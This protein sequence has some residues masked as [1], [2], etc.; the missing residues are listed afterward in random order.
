MGDGA[1][2]E[3]VD[4]RA[5]T[6]LAAKLDQLFQE[7]ARANGKPPSHAEVAR[8]INARS[9]GRT[10]SGVYIWQLRTG[11]KDN[12]TKRHLEALADYFRVPPGYFFD[13]AGAPPSP[14]AAP[15][16]GAHHR[17]SA[18]SPAPFRV[19]GAAEWTAGAPTA[20]P[21]GQALLDPGTVATR[22]RFLFDHVHPQSGP[23]TDED[24]AEAVNGNPAKYGGVRL[25]PATVAALREGRLPDPAPDGDAPD[26]PTDSA[27][28]A[29]LAA[30]ASFFGVG[31]DYLLGDD[32]DAVARTE[33]EVRFLATLRDQRVR[34]VALRAAGLPPEILDTLGTMIGQFRA[35]LNLPETATAATPATAAATVGG[36]EP[37]QP[38]G[39]GTGESHGNAIR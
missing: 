22:L 25:A 26:A 2:D 18:A 21:A 27:L 9:G 10:I 11:K 4:E 19:P 33:E 8:A 16:A 5:G 14:V 3:Q 31:A 30:V 29:T 34:Q 15:S 35:Q 13:D 7:A 24:V 39:A 32:P 37:G 28:P 20:G 23:Y 1:H 6:D 17:P 38:H 36:A 12:P